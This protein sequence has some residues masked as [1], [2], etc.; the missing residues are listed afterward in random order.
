MER[1]WPR[2]LLWNPI[3]FV[4]IFST[5]LL[6]ASSIAALPIRAQ[7]ISY[8][9]I[10]R[11]AADD[12]HQV[13]FDEN[14]LLVIQLEANPSA[15]YLWEVVQGDFSLIVQRQGDAP[16]FGA[17]SGMP[18]SPLLQ[19]L[20]FA[21]I[22]SGET[23]LVLALR[24]PWEHTEPPLAT[25]AV[26]IRTVGPFTGANLPT[27]TPTPS[28]I[29][30]VEVAAADIAASGLPTHFNW[31]EQGKCTPVKN[32]GTCGSCWA[33]ATTGVLESAIKI[34]DGIERDLSEQ[35]LLSC[36]TQGWGCNGGFWAHEY[37]QNKIPPGELDAGA[38]YESDF[39]YLGKRTTCNGPHQHYEKILSWGLVAGYGI[40]SVAALK[41]AIYNYGPVTA[42]VCAGSAFIRYTGGIFQTDESNQCPYGTNHAVMLVGWDDAQG[43]WY[44]R[45]SWGPSWGENGM[46]RIKYG[47]SSV[48]EDASYVAYKRP[49]TSGGSQP[50]GEQSIKLFLPVVARQGVSQSPPAPP[51]PALT[52]PTNGGFENGPSVW[53]EFSQQGWPVILDR[54]RLTVLP[55]DG[56]WAAWLG[57][58]DDEVASI[59]QT[60][61]VPSDHPYLAYWHWIHSAD[62][63]GA[64]RASVIVDGVVLESYYLCATRNTNGWVQRVIDLSSYKGKT[65]D[66]Q[67]RVETNS[68][69]TS[70]WYLDDIWF[71]GSSA[72]Q[73]GVFAAEVSP[74]VAGKWDMAR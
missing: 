58:D 37:H 17:S 54:G 64:D 59:R 40:P 65:V 2:R 73:P 52:V 33:F 50:N 25:F 63:C 67:L 29:P 56:N 71:Q 5:L 66:L 14:T 6:A 62:V 44:L 18:G 70:N 9:E 74:Q 21:A 19:T 72:A 15:G 61:M 10:V 13:T 45:N 24:R 4:S 8:K 7:G 57:G 49:A 53:T 38:V 36:N 1:G 30:V 34:H 48:G 31:C 20:R 35:Y 23:E 12:G 26:T 27:P 55:H 39:P 41:Q 22:A 43:I 16:E 42:G 68:S 3:W 32:Q 46:M 51:P 60:V 47:I 69:G 28:P 11:T